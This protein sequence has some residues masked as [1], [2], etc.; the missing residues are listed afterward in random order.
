M[1]AQEV[2][3][4]ANSIYER[5]PE[6]DNDGNLNNGKNNQPYV[7][8]YM[9][10]SS[11]RKSAIIPLNCNL[12]L[13]GISG[14]IPLNIFRINP[15]KLPT[16]YQRKDVAF[17][18]KSETQKIS[19]GQDWTTDLTGQLVLLDLKPNEGENTERIKDI[20][21]EE[22]EIPNSDLQFVNPFK[23]YYGISSTWPTRS[24]G[25]HHAG[26][27]L[28][29]PVGVSVHAP[30]AAKI[31]DNSWFNN[32]NVEFER[33]MYDSKGSSTGY[34]NFVC[35]EFTTPLSAITQEHVLLIYLE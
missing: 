17:I 7:G 1:Y 22:V 33:W 32:D 30:A 11:L 31:W 16:G 9:N 20:D 3:D 15:D 6:K 35:M 25:A 8:M 10:N 2:E 19:S 21:I 18:V 29:L 27:D 24:S 13:D 4:L 26:L 14:I 5:H 34:G 12:R 23:G 28:L